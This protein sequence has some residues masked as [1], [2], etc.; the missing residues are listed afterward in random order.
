MTISLWGGPLDGSE[1]AELLNLPLFIVANFH[2]DKPIYKRFA[3]EACINRCEAVPY[4]FVG[5]E[6]HLH[7]PSPDCGKPEQAH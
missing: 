7:Y 3:C 6:D 4:V 2:S 1:R 5:Y